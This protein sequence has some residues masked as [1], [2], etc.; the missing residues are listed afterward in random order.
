[1]EIFVCPF[2]WTLWREKFVPNHM[3]SLLDLP[4]ASEGLRPPWIVEENHLVGVFR[5][6]EDPA[7]PEAPTEE[8]VI[9]LI[10]WLKPR[11][12][13]PDAKFLIHCTAGLGRSPAVGYIVWSLFLGAGQEDEAF[14]NMVN[15]CQQTKLIPNRLIVGLADEL[16]G[17]HG[18]LV[19]PL[20]EWNR[21][22]PWARSHW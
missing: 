6:H 3:V 1:M 2:D 5:D 4:E 9:A 10:R 12:G 11:V 7:L 15:S 19:R 22:V 20:R 18:A 21:R 8:D 16:L 14:R 17:R 13:D